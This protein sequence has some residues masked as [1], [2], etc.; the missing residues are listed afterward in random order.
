M[1][2]FILLAILSISLAH[3][4]DSLLDEYKAWKGINGKTASDGGFTNKR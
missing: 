2:Y 3:A 4:S 1:K